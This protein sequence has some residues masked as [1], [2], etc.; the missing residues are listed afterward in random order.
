MLTI[1]ITRSHRIYYLYITGNSKKWI[2]IRNWNSVSV[3]DFNEVSGTTTFIEKNYML[4][5]I[6]VQEYILNQLL[7]D[8]N[9]KQ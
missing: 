3:L 4:L 2:I 7:H 9:N 8:Q 1:N 5:K 6:K